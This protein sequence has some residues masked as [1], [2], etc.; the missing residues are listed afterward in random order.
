[1]RG[2]EEEEE[3]GLEFANLEANDEEERE[4]EDAVEGETSE[5]T[6]V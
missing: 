6:E 1:M 5:A 3:E 2:E 4:E